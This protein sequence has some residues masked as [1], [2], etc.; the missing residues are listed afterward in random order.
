MSLKSLVCLSLL[1]LSAFAVEVEYHGD[2]TIDYF[3]AFSEERID[4][5]T[6]NNVHHDI[7]VEGHFKFN[8]GIGM[9]LGIA[10]TSLNNGVQSVGPRGNRPLNTLDDDLKGQAQRVDLA[11]AYLSWNFTDGASFMF[12]RFQ[13]AAG[14]INSYRP[15]RRNV[16]YSPIFKERTIN[17]GLGLQAS[18][19]FGYIG[20]AGEEYDNVNIFLSYDAPLINSRKQTLNIQPIIDFRFNDAES[21]KWH[22]GLDNDYSS[23]FKDLEYSIHNV[24]GWMAHYESSTWNFL[25]EPNLKYNGFSL[26]MGYYYASLATPPASRPNADNY[27]ALLQRNAV[28]QQTDMPV[29][30]FY[31]IEPFIPVTP[32]W[33]IGLPI[34][35]HDPSVYVED[36]H[37]WE[38]GIAGYVYPTDVAEV[39]IQV[40]AQNYADRKFYLMTEF[41]TE[42][43]F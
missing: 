31:Y 26:G 9:V 22:L 17:A 32:K 6:A 11:D 40:G 18:D 42:I 25:L 3:G 10:T 23:S 8:E 12:G 5:N 19:F 27:E 1:S 38:Y 34:S 15:Y 29:Q 43:H 20:T 24:I 28:T 21:R 30:E 41:Y 14:S 36:D 35:R 4:S 2:A 16:F 33:A 37:F 13:R 7:E 39:G